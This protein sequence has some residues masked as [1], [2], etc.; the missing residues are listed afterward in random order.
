M[1]GEVVL[2]ASGVRVGFPTERGLIRAVDG[3]EL[4]LRAG[5]MLGLVGESGCGKTT[6]GRSLLGLVPDWARVDGEVTVDG[7]DLL[8]VSGRELQD[9]RGPVLGVIFQDPMTRLDPLMRVS[10]HFLEVLRRHS[11]ELS[12]R[13]ARKRSIDVLAAMGIPPS[14]FEHY[15][16]EFSGGMRQRIMIALALVLRPRVLVAD[17]PTT[18]LDVI[19]EAE[20]IRILNDLRRNFDT[21]LI[22]I[23]HALGIV[24]ESCDS[25]AVM[26]AGRIVERGETRQVLAD[27]L[28]PYTRGLLRSSILLDTTELHYIPGE[29]PDLSNPP[30]GCRFH[31]RCHDSMGICSVREPQ[32]TAK[33]GA[34]V[35][36]WLYDSKAAAKFETE[37]SATPARRGGAPE[38]GDA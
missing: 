4:E 27:P 24:A 8:H 33:N 10:D 25:V 18:A 36:C 7:R 38:H 9:M 31:P 19:V 26:Y 22:L 3:V 1:S 6:L 13:E 11:P 37:Q 35:E 29:P 5:Q 17:E 32:T 14:R 21:A 15:P 28:H 20:I 12:S 23:T 34:D 16:H 2:S 30:P